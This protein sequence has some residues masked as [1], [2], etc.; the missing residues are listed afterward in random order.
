VLL[1]GVICKVGGDTEVAKEDR[2]IIV[3]EH[4]GGLYV[5]M[6]KSVNVKVAGLSVGVA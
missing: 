2:T 1:I 4:V 3:D 5:P 6:N